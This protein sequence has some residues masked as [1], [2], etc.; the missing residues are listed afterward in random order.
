MRRL[1]ADSPELEYTVVMLNKRPI[2]FLVEAEEG[3]NGWV[4]IPD[5]QALWNMESRSGFTNDGR[6]K[7]GEEYNTVMLSS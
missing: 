5:S 7:V 1:T 6:A 3:E 4:R 2:K